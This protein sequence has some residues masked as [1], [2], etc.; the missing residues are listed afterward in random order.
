MNW[1]DFMYIMAFVLMIAV[2]YLAIDMMVDD[3][4]YALYNINGDYIVDVSMSQ[5]E[6]LISNGKVAATVEG[7]T[8]DREYLA[9]GYL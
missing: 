4:T 7:I 8:K 9:L 1:F 6:F 2:L 5:L 3:E